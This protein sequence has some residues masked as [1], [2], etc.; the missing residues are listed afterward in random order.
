MAAILEGGNARWLARL[1]DSP[2]RN[3]EQKNWPDGG[4][5][6]QSSGRMADR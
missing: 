5:V 1:A 3:R 6:A 4:A 2:S